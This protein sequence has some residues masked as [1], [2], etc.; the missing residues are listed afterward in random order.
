V[1]S[2]EGRGMQGLNGIGGRKAGGRGLHGRTKHECKMPRSER[3]NSLR[4]KLMTFITCIGPTAVAPAPGAHIVTPGHPSFQSN[5][6][7][8]GAHCG[9]DSFKH[10]ICRSLDSS[11]AHIGHS[12]PRPLPSRI[13]DSHRV[14]ACLNLW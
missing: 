2:V 5:E 3:V 7:P 4:N 9:R 12:Y 11:L 6:Y 13:T 1:C 8:G 14:S 10:H